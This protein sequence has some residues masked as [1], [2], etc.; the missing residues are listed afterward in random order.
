MTI[1]VRSPLKTA[2]HRKNLDKPR[3]R[4]LII[5]T[6]GT[7]GMIENIETRALEPFNFDHLIENVP[8]IQLLDIDI[9]SVEFSD[10]IDSSSM[11]PS[12]WQSIARVIEEHYSD[13]DGFVVLHGTDTMAYTASALSFM[14]ENLDKP[15]IITGSQ[16]PIGDVRTDG[17][18]NLITALQVA[19]ARTSDGRPVVREVA[20]LFEDFL[21]RGNR[22]TK[23]SSDNFCAFSSDNYPALASFGLGIHYNHDVLLNQPPKG[24]LKVHYDFDTN[25]MMIDLFPG[26]QENVVRHLFNTPGIRGIVLKT[27]G[28]GNGPSDPW[29]ITALKE[30]VGRGIVIVN[31]SQCSNGSVMPERYSAGLGISQTGVISGHDLTAEASVTKLMHLLG[32]GFDT[33]KIREMMSRSLCGEMTTD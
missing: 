4:I 19:S 13:F 12:H 26:I 14:L 32:C 11:N 15:V 17:E 9:E 24:D 1:P 7:I 25:V 28:S 23:H 21:W 30:A 3:P 29:F 2:C 10:P 31:I 6:G 22:A 33:A 8:K 20:I 18:E 16:L 27:F 5:Y